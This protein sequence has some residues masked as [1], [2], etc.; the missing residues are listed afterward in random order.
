MIGFRINGIPLVLFPDTS[1]NVQFIS[2]A[3]S[4][5]L[6]DDFS[7]PFSVPRA[8]NEQVL[9]HVHDIALHERITK[10]EGA[11]M[12]YQGVRRKV[13]VLYVE[14]AD[15]DRISLS[16]T[17]TG[18]VATIR[19]LRLPQ[20]KLGEPILTDGVIDYAKAVNTQTWPAVPCCFPMYYAPD[21]Y[22]S[23]N[24]DWNPSAPEWDIT[25]SYVINDLVTYTTEIYISGSPIR[26]TF[27]YQCI[28]NTVAQRPELNP[29]KW[30]RTAYGIVN[31]WSWTAEAFH[32]NSAG[33]NF[34]T[35]SPC[36]YLKRILKEA[37]AG[38]GYLV[39]GTFMD[40][41]RYH[42]LF[43]YNNHPL[44][45]GAQSAYFLAHQTGTI[46]VSGDVLSDS[47]VPG[48]D[49]VTPPNQDAAGVWDPVGMRWQCPSAGTYTLRAFVPYSIPPGSNL[50]VYFVRELGNV[51]IASQIHPTPAEIWVGYSG[52][53][54]FTF[55]ASAGDVGQWFFF[56]A[57]LPWGAPLLLHDCWVEGWK[58]GDTVTNQFS[59]TIRP[60]E[61]VPDMELSQLLLDLQAIYGVQVIVDGDARVVNLDF[62]QPA[63]DRAPVE[64]TANVRSPISIDTTLR[65]KG[66]TWSWD[67]GDNPLP[68]L[69][70]LTKQGE[71]THYAAVPPPNG[72]GVWCL[73]LGDRRVL[74]SKID[75]GGYAWYPSGFLFDSYT[76][77]EDET[78]E[79]R[80]P[81]LAP[82]Q[83]AIV[84]VELEEFLVPAVPDKGTSA[85]FTSET[86]RS[87]LLIGFYH[88][89]QA[90]QNG[91]HYPFASS[92][93]YRMDGSL[94]NSPELDFTSANG[95]VALHQQRL[96]D[97]QVNAD[98]IT[99]DMEVTPDYLDGRLYER[100]QL[101]HG[102]RCMVI[103]MPV[104]LAD[105]R[106]VLIAK[107]VQLIKLAN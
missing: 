16:F 85:Y 6:V 82:M 20:M 57:K 56:A 8:G 51:I 67:P 68:D 55:N 103:S 100:P 80:T 58:N 5:D 30:R 47:R 79:E 3:L 70:K 44:D 17:I 69:S 52:I 59:D 25:K 105:G 98:P 78:A 104:T 50:Q 106:G 102:Q 39:R 62:Q 61:H 12:E 83:S 11:I 38:L 29:D 99:C 4:D 33:L 1:V 49:V 23:E 66:I 36:F 45:Q 90:N 72:P 89:M 92:F 91:K 81:A 21:F 18:F 9:G 65:T 10:F 87:S 13:G 94:I 48:Q 64:M 60:E 19:G 41:A 101:I 15:D 27:V 2:A 93:R 31:H 73:V 14:Q 84:G 96:A 86:G 35:I 7:L 88:G 43:L 40:D 46:T 53:S 37:F 28:A 71:Y 54:T 32:T 74:I 76:I 22:G 24:P 97:A 26:Y 34:Y 63:L 77:G 107:K 75:P 95:P 42:R